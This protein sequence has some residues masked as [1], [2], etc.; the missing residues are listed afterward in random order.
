MEPKRPTFNPETGKRGFTE[1]KSIVFVDYRHE[2]EDKKEIE[3]LEDYIS[4]HSGIM[5]DLSNAKET[6]ENVEDL[7]REIE[8]LKAKNAALESGQGQ[9]ETE[10]PKE[11]EPTES[12]EPE[13]EVV[14]EDA[15]NKHFKEAVQQRKEG[16]FDKA[17]EM[18]KEIPEESRKFNHAQNEIRVAEAKKKNASPL[19]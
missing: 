16:N 10:Q 2:T 11:E 3:F 7:K 1:S 19:L 6:V 12:G 18:L 5:V 13:A 8:E 17:I 9:P 4:K 14:D 15:I